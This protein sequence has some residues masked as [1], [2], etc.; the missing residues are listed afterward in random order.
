LPRKSGSRKRWW[1][2][3]QLI[4]HCSGAEIGSIWSSCYEL[5]A[6]VCEII[7]FGDEKPGDP[8]YLCA[9]HVR[10]LSGAGK[11][12]RNPRLVAKEQKA[13]ERAEKQLVKIVEKL[14]G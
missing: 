9:K 13:F 10:E 3:P 14:A 8:M 4:D 5:A 12:R 1:D 7:A 2:T 6:E 11:V